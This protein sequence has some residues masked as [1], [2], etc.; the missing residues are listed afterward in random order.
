[1]NC[2]G[3]YYFRINKIILLFFDKN[4]LICQKELIYPTFQV[5]SNI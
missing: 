1:M 4:S 3:K 2:K 5:M